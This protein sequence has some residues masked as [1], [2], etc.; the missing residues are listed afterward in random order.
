ME[1]EPV[2]NLMAA[3]AVSA[4]MEQQQVLVQE[5]R[6]KILENVISAKEW[7]ARAGAGAGAAVGAGAQEGDPAVGAEMRL[8]N[9]NLLLHA[10]GL[11]ATQITV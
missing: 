8:R 10:L 3:L 11:D 5:L 9:T 1:D 4:S 6:E 2:W 7:A